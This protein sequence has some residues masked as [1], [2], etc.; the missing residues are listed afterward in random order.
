[1][2]ITHYSSYKLWK[3]SIYKQINKKNYIFFTNKRHNPNSFESLFVFPKGKEGL[4]SRTQ[5]S[6]SIKELVY[7]MTIA[8]PT[9]IDLKKL[10]EKK[11]KQIVYR[12]LPPLLQV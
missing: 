12:V 11:I 5:K 6:Y 9:S 2:P 8:I 4:K 1:M 10:T 3:L 7:F